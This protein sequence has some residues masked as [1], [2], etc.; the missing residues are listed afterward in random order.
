MSKDER[1]AEFD[2]TVIERIESS[3]EDG[4]R[5]TERYAC[6]CYR[7]KGYE[8]DLGTRDHWDNYICSNCNKKKS[9]GKLGA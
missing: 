9:D 2:G 7:E 8:S 3:D 5:L 4:D 1:C 6:G